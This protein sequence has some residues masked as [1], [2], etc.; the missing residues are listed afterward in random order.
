MIHMSVLPPAFMKTHPIPMT[1]LA[2][3]ALSKHYKVY[4][5]H[6]LKCL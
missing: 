6:I 1:V 2:F 3:V 4:M 5:P